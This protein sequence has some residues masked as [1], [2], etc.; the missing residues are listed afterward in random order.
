[1]MKYFTIIQEKDTTAYR[2]F[3]EIVKRKTVL[4]CILFLS[5]LLCTCRL[6]NILILNCRDLIDSQVIELVFDYL[7]QYGTHCAFYLE[8]NLYLQFI[9]ALTGVRDLRWWKTRNYHL[10]THFTDFGVKNIRYPK[11]PMAYILNRL[12]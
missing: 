7:I 9:D 12:S 11:Q 6:R 10:E 8:C 2:Y 1:M 3:G 4:N 5:L